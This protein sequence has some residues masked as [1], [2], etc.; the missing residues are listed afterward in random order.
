MN[1]RQQVEA[2][3]TGIL[4]HNDALASIKTRQNYDSAEDVAAK[5]LDSKDKTAKFGRRQEAP[6]EGAQDFGAES[7][8]DGD[9]ALEPSHRRGLGNT[10]GVQGPI[11]TATAA[12]NG[13]GVAAF[14]FPARDGLAENPFD[15]SQDFNS[16][17]NKGPQTGSPDLV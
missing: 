9:D 4:N 5:S 8:Q 16:G 11:N 10:V 15:T 14:L 7:L 3:K 1:R 17:S 13:N 2:I 12:G 6:H